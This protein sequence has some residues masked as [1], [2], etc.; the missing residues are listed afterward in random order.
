MPLGHCLGG[1]GTALPR[2]HGLAASA[3]PSLPVRGRAANGPLLSHFVGERSERP[4]RY[5]LIGISRCLDGVGAVLGKVTFSTPFSNFAAIFSAS[6]L[7]G[8]VKARLNEP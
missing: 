8:K 3:L 7:S 6:T 2:S 1:E 5:P 4:R